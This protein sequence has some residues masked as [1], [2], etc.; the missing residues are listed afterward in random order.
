WRRGALGT[1]RLHRHDIRR[2]GDLFRGHV[3][4]R[5]DEDAG[6]AAGSGSQR[7]VRRRSHQHEARV[8]R[9]DLAQ[10]RQVRTVSNITNATA[11]NKMFGA[12]AASTGDIAPPDPSAANTLSAIQ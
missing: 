6:A 10:E 3:A 8:V 12:H 9:A 2:P 1:F 5:R 7:D 11:L 4:A